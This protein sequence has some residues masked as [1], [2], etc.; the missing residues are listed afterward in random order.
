MKKI[1]A[2]ALALLMVISMI[3]TMA[4]MSS[5]AE[6]FTSGTYGSGAETWRQKGDDSHFYYHTQ[7]LLYVP[8]TLWY[9]ADGLAE[10]D[11]GI[12]AKVG[13]SGTK[14][15]AETGEWTV[16]GITNGKFVLNITDLSGETKDV[17]CPPTTAGTVGDN[18]ILRF[19]TADYGAPAYQIQSGNSYTIQLSIYL[20]ANAGAPDYVG[21]KVQNISWTAGKAD[22]G[23]DKMYSKNNPLAETPKFTGDVPDPYEKPVEVNWVTYNDTWFEDHKTWGKVMMVGFLSDKIPDGGDTGDNAIKAAAKIVVTWP[24]G[25]KKEVDGFVKGNEGFLMDY[26]SNPAIGGKVNLYRVPYDPF[27]KAVDGKY[28][29]DGVKVEFIRKTDGKVMYTGTISSAK[30]DMTKYPVA[31][32]LTPYNGN[33][34]EGNKKSDW[35]VWAGTLCLLVNM[36][37]LIGEDDFNYAGAKLEVKLDGKAVTNDG[38]LH[39]VYKWGEQ[40]DGT[41][42]N[43]LRL[44]VGKPAEGKHTVQITL[45]YGEETM[46]TTEPLEVVYSKASTVGGDIGDMNGDGKVNGGD[47]NYL[48]R[49]LANWKSYPLPDMGIGDMNGDGKVNGGDR[50]YLARTLAGWSGYTL[51]GV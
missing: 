38:L 8:K 49:A 40:E 43:L 46:Y 36:E 19:E 17:V 18:M 41:F 24:D 35:E 16:G 14:F 47:R 48:A 9:G 4:L 29:M 10:G 30:P 15:N 22:Q 7:F 5:A 3:P 39:S 13:Y 20:D 28:N 26:S 34:E 33:D 27:P 51:P 1:T 44:N 32:S 50:T 21:S 25:T 6:E 45:T 2:L 11:D 42:K 12:N 23:T 37:R 31:A